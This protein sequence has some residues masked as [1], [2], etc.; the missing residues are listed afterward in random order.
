MQNLKE[1]GNVNSFD[2]MTKLINKLRFDMHK[3][4]IWESVMIEEKGGHEANF[5]DFVD[6]VT[7]ESEEQSSLFGR[8]VF[9][10]KPESKPSNVKGSSKQPKVPCFNGH[11][12]QLNVFTVDQTDG[13]SQKCSLTKF[14]VS[15]PSRF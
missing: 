8:R 14:E 13:I 15:T 7:R 12:N 9:V 2:F 1:L 4:W 10:S 3:S 6:H 5:N 11:S